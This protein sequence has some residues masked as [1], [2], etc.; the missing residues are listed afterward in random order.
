M[1][2]VSLQLF[3]AVIDC[4][5]KGQHCEYAFGN[6]IQQRSLGIVEG[7]KLKELKVIT[8]QPNRLSVKE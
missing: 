4:S 8:L 7:G 3:D 2:I 1:P 5:R 6:T